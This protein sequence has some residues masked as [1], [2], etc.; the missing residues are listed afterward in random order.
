MDDEFL[1]RNK[2]RSGSMDDEFFCGN[3]APSGV[4]VAIKFDILNEDDIVKYI[5]HLIFIFQFFNCSLFVSS[6]LLSLWDQMVCTYCVTLTPGG[7]WAINFV[8]L[9]KDESIGWNGY[10]S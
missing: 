5:L 1:Y 10:Q 3:K 9:L 8:Y 4:I 2:T 7:G 6:L